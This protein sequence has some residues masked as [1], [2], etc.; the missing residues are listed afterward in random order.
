MSRLTELREKYAVSELD[1]QPW[2]FVDHEGRYAHTS[3]SCDDVTRRVLRWD[4][5]PGYEQAQSVYPHNAF[6]YD[7]YHEGRRL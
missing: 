3:A 4:P 5:R 1:D 7:A 6:G 2:R